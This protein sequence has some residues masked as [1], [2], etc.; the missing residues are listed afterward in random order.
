MLW[1]VRIE[2]CKIPT[3]FWVEDAG[4]CEGIEGECKNE[5]RFV[6][7]EI[8]TEMHCYTTQKCSMTDDILRI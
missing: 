5:I 8:H 6:L 4:V 3:G 2:V 1:K 7:I